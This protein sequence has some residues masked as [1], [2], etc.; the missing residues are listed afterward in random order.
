MDLKKEKVSQERYKWN[1][2][3]FGNYNSI[4]GYFQVQSVLENAKGDSLLDIACG[5][6]TLTALFCKSK[7][8]KR[9]VGVDA[10]KIQLK[11]AKKNCPQA[12]FHESLIENFE[13]DEKFDTVVML[14]LLEHVVDPVFVL[15]KAASFLKKDG[16]L[17]VH[18]PNALAINRIIARI[19]GTLKSEYELS[20]YDIKVAG[21]RRSYDMDLLLKDIRKAGLK[22]IK[23]GGVFYKM[24]STPQMD[25]LLKYGPWKGNKFGWGRVG[26][27][28]KDWRFEFCRAC[29]EFG[30]TRPN[31]CNIIYA[32]CTKE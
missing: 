6:G 31:E 32:C 5:D 26:G 18:V 17:I 3:Q 20:P 30:K 21:H 24:L 1:R 14:N 12:E 19:M 2:S 8:F 22:V 11:R 4:L 9:V 28:K 25:W 13:T 23:T 7:K 15:K 16:V 27:P 10:S 29:Y